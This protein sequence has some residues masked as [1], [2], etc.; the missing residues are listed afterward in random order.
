MREVG[1]DGSGSP[2]ISRLRQEVCGFVESVSLPTLFMVT[3]AGSAI[4][5][6]IAGLEFPDMLVVLL[7]TTYAIMAFQAV[8]ARH[9]A[10]L[11]KNLIRQ[12][13]SLWLRLNLVLLTV[14]MGAFLIPIYFTP[15]AAVFATTSLPTLYILISAYRTTR[16]TSTLLNS[17]IFAAAIVV[18]YMRYTIDYRGWQLTGFCV[19]TAVVGLGCFASLRLSGRMV[20]HGFTPSQIAGSRLWLLWLASLSYAVYDHELTAINS[21]IMLSTAVLAVTSIILP[22][23]CLQKSIA[24]LGPDKT[25]VLIGFTP[26]VVLVMEFVFLHEIDTAGVAPAVLVPVITVVFAF[27]QWRSSGGAAAPS[28]GPAAASSSHGTA[29]TATAVSKR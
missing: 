9:V 1:P 23:Y 11:H 7:T 28:S 16:R 20:E 19:A 12:H 5:R 24:V 21:E 26:M 8:N 10:T 3:T 15:F 27:Y 2:K 13:K 14:S 17:I 4:L 18:F 22:V 25:G 6:R 29:D